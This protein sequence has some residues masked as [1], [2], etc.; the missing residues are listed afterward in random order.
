MKKY[1]AL[2]LTLVLVVAVSVMAVSAATEDIDFTAGGIVSAVCPRCGGE[3]VD[4]LPL[5]KT[6]IDTWA[7]NYDT[8]NGTHYY[9]EWPMAIGMAAHMKRYERCN[10]CGGSGH[11][12]CPDCDG[13]GKSYKSY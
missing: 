12:E 7:G 13:E 11:I 8:A 9:V 6:L 1:L 4:W 5:T 2:L 3:K 10:T